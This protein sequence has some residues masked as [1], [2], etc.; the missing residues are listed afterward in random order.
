MEKEKTECYGHMRANI[1]QKG[2]HTGEDWVKCLGNKWGG[3]FSHQIY[4]VALMSYHL[5]GHCT[6]PH[7]LTF[8]VCTLINNLKDSKKKKK[9]SSQLLPVDRHLRRKDTACICHGMN[10]WMTLTFLNNEDSWWVEWMTP[11]IWIPRGGFSVWNGIAR[12]WCL[13]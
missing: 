5:H 8:K 3:Q 6:E 4:D 11:F 12:K 13:S 2:T 10:A 9:C 7:Y 1:F